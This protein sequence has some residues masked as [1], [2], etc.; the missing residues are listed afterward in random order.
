MR[1][2]QDVKLSKELSEHTKLELISKFTMWYD[3][4][5]QDETKYSREYLHVIRSIMDNRIPIQCKY[6]AM[7]EV[8]DELSETLPEEIRAEIVGK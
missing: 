8:M 6:L 1:G 5:D 4:T 7:E 3:D 2:Y